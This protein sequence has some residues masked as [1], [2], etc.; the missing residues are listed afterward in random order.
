MAMKQDLSFFSVHHCGLV[1]SFLTPQQDW[2]RC[3][4]NFL[5]FGPTA[6]SVTLNLMP[7]WSRNFRLVRVCSLIWLLIENFALYAVYSPLFLCCEK[8]IPTELCTCFF[9]CVFS[10]TQILT[11]CYMLVF[12]NSTNNNS[13]CVHHSFQERFQLN[14]GVISSYEFQ[15]SELNGTQHYYH[16][17]QLPLALPLPLSSPARCLVSLCCHLLC[18]LQPLITPTSSQPTLRPPAA[19][20]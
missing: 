5:S 10:C 1:Y 18:S 16:H 15:L 8:Y 9:F 11:C 19:D 13:R 2:C 6:S 14:C 20:F 4:P 7:P 3:M 17:L 12:A